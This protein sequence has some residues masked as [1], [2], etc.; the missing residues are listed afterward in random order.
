MKVSVYVTA[1][2]WK[3]AVMVM[4]PDTVAGDGIPDQLSKKYLAPGVHGERVAVTVVSPT[5]RV[6][7]LD[8]DVLICV[9]YGTVTVAG[10][11]EP[12]SGSLGWKVTV[13]SLTVRTKLAVM[14]QSSVMLPPDG[15][16]DQLSREY[17]Y[18]AVAYAG[19]A[20]THV[21]PMLILLPSMVTVPPL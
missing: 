17:V 18:C 19:A 9:P 13:Y 5:V 20:V 10:L 6:L 16:P 14:V 3:L 7:G 11:M 21:P 4:S 2:L 12:N 15:T 8:E 1:S